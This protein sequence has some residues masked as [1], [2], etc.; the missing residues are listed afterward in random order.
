M[1]RRTDQGDLKIHLM[2][3]PEMPEMFL[4]PPKVELIS[5]ERTDRY[6]INAKPEHLF[7]RK[8]LRAITNRRVEDF[9]DTYNLLHTA[10]TTGRKQIITY[11]KSKDAAAISKGIKILAGEPEYFKKE[12]APRLAHAETDLSPARMKVLAHLIAAELN[13]TANEISE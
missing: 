2:H 1:I 9:L 10:G 13:K 6:V 8:V 3:V 7:F 4:D 5:I 11:A 12:L